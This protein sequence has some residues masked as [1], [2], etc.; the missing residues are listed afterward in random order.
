MIESMTG[1]GRGT[2]EA[3][4]TTATVE[5]R[6]VNK[7]HNDVS[8]RMPS[9]LSAYEADIEAR[10]KKAFERGQ[11]NVY[12]DVEEKEDE[13]LPIRVDEEA[14]ARYARL[15]NRVRAAAGIEE[16]LRL[17]HVLK[18]SDIFTSVEEAEADDADEETW[19]VVQAALDRALDTLRDM[20]RREGEALR[21]DLDER[22]DLIAEHLQSVEE[23]AP[24]RIGEA[25]DRLNR[26][27][28]ELMDSDRIDPERLEM[29]IA[30]LADK[31]DITEECVR[32][33]SHLN[34]FRE[35]L[36]DDDAVGRK[37]NFIA[38][39][40]QREVNT[41]GSKANDTV[42]TRH[43][44]AMKEEVEKIREQIRNVE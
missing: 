44:V 43:T 16:P 32:L 18:F 19:Q 2:A 23:R 33:R 30:I 13:A 41:I 8:V 3:Y 11:F 5:V 10:V 26:R 12:I 22:L 17:E 1:F 20:R 37:L 34:M 36:A 7:R 15:L 40:M 27:L 29:E 9:A 4:G 24:E 31:Y 25:Q 35:A 28:A 6:S 42:L 38:Q 14:T 21:H 39:E